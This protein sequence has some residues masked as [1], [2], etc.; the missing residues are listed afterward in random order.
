M[1]PSRLVGRLASLSSCLLL[2][3]AA[4]YAAEPTR[5]PSCVV[6]H[7]E[8]GTKF[9]DDAHAAADMTC[10]TCHGG[11]P[12]DMEASA[13]SHGGGFRGAPSRQQ[14]PTFCANC[15]SN[16]LLMKQYG[17]PAQ[18]FE[19]YKLSEHGHAWARGDVRAAVCTDCHGT[20][21]ILRADDT[22]SSVYPTN[23]PATC[24]RCHDD[25]QLMGAHGLPSH[26]FEEYRQSVHGKALLEGQ[27]KAAPSCAS[28]H[29]NHAALP[30]AAQQIGNVCGQCHRQIVE[31]LRQSAH[32]AAVRAGALTECISCHDH[33]LIQPAS[34]ERLK[35][36][37]GKCHAPDSPAAAEARRMY[38]LITGAQ[39][40]YDEAVAAVQRLERLGRTAGDLKTHLEEAHTKLVQTADVQHLLQAREVERYTIAVTEAA[41]E[42]KHRAAEVHVELRARK[43]LLVVLWIAVLAMAGM[44]LT[45]RARASK[46][47]TPSPT[48]GDSR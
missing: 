43:A 27:N 14:I 16:R 28:C 5:Q 38:E 37:C 32:A 21:G 11:N 3:A 29:G 4:A 9:A 6:C 31:R 23:V 39:G 35:I 25:A 45:K 44:L 1:P 8:A 36:V 15:H 46:E 22:R 42:V 7:S 12:A 34:P 18:E 30:P 33:H 13:M 41:D 17:L 47:L 26:A 10:V 20:H 2:V 40:D 24:G 19:D 48:G